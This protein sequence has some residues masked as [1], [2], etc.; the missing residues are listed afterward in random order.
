MTLIRVRVVLLMGLRGEPAAE[1]NAQAGEWG[2]VRTT[3]N[4]DM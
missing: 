2:V 1:T 3:N 4:R